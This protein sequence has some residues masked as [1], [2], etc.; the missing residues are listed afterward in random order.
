MSVSQARTIFRHV[1][2]AAAAL[3]FALLCVIPA[4][5]DGFRWPQPG[6]PGTPVVLTY[7]FSNLLDGAFGGLLSEADIRTS[8][9]EAFG[10]WST[11][12]PLSFIERP[13]S[14]PNPSERDYSAAAH[15]HIRI[16]YHP[17][18]D[19]AVLAHA[20]LPRD[21][22]SGLSG[23]IHFNEV[24]SNSWS[25]AGGFPTIDFLEV[26][27]H[28]IGHAVGVEHILYADAIM[29][30]YYRA[31]Y[32]GHGTAYL[33]EP[34][35]SAVRSLY[36]WGVG[37]V[38]PMPEPSTMLLLATGVVTFFVRRWALRTRCPASPLYSTDR[39]L[40]I[41]IKDARLALDFTPLW[42]SMLR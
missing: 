39:T 6:G 9:T 7:S 3:S 26:I 32:G 21:T 37:S 15:P 5:A 36:G 42:R 11:Y 10:L 13:D 34:D 25:I 30:P 27:T 24:T 31:R 12:A 29:Q 20:F 4:H 23:D 18:D 38:R 14:G 35:I 33:L 22:E 28:E 17:I 41:G 2:R 19:D 40:T 1:L 8:T 16:G